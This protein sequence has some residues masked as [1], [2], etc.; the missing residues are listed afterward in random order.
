MSK[1]QAFPSSLLLLWGNSLKSSGLRTKILV[2]VLILLLTELHD[3]G[4]VVC[5]SFLLDVLKNRPKESLFPFRTAL[6]LSH[7]PLS[8]AEWRT[9][10]ITSLREGKEVTLSFFCK[11]DQRLRW[12]RAACEVLGFYPSAALEIIMQWMFSFAVG[13]V[14][15]TQSQLM[16]Q[17]LKRRWWWESTAVRF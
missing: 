2:P 17:V 9:W 12:H 11:K 4:L 8:G 13:N 14:M 6:Y 3:L 1:S 15:T 16:V 10:I 5:L 7:F